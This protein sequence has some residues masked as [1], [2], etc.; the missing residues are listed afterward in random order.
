M[1]LDDASSIPS[2]AITSTLA[3]NIRKQVLVGPAQGWKGW[4]MRLFTINGVGYTPKHRHPWPHINYVLKGKGI[5]FHGGREHPVQEGSVAFIPED[6]EHQFRCDNDEGLS[7]L[8]IVP[9]NGD[10]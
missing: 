3:E 9:E 6:E 7:F 8:C 2:V 4:V 10:K 1:F 5:L